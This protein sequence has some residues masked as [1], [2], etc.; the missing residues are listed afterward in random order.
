MNGN[1]VTLAVRTIKN[2]ELVASEL[3]TCK[4][5]NFGY[6]SGGEIFL[7]IEYFI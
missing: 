7:L 4:G 3:N 2:I 6:R 5:S 1:K